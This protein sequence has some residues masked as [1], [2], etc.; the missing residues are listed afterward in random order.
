MRDNG[1]RRSLQ[2]SPGLRR[3]GG[4]GGDR[5]PSASNFVQWRDGETKRGA[6]FK[7]GTRPLVKVHCRTL[8][9]YGW[10]LLF[11]VN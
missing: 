2:C 4:G 11:D 7:E 8:K 10:R 5:C 1:S 3:R 6:S 9:K